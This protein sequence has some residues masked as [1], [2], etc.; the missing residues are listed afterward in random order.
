[1]A[2]LEL[3]H[4]FVFVDEAETKPKGGL[5]ERLSALGLEP[6]FMRRHMGQGTANLCYALDNAYLELLHVVDEDELKASPLGRAGFAER[7]NWRKTG[8]SPFG[9]SCRGALPGESWTYRNPDF[10]PGVSIAISVESDD[11]AMPFVFSSPGKAQPSEWT[12]GR[13]GRQQ[14]AAGFTRLTI[15]RLT[16]PRLP[17]AGG[18]LD[19]FHRA[20][21][22]KELDIAE[23][24]PELLIGLE[25]D[26]RLR[27]PSFMTV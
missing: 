13:A 10:P 24:E 26:R 22:I 15:E 8:A 27:L 6:S 9:I 12:D 4:V 3:D 18:A 14:T 7:A 16:L 5:V 17:A 23:G 21:L 11:P 25:P 2:G 1:M 19:A 20:G